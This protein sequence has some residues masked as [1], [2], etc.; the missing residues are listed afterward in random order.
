[1]VA[2]PT[3]PT[4]TKIKVINVAVISNNVTTSDTNKKARTDIGANS[5]WPE[6]ELKQLDM[7]LSITFPIVLM[8]LKIILFH[9]TTT[10]VHCENQGAEPEHMPGRTRAAEYTC[11]WT[12]KSGNNWTDQYWAGRVL[13]N[14]HYNRIDISRTSSGPEN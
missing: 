11:T 10:E 13:L 2:R 7:R 1:M 9:H 3:K 8:Y 6:E 5:E 12:G 4:R 14:K